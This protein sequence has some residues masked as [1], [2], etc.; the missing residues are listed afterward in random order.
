MHY[1]CIAEATEEKEK[2]PV[3]FF[4]YKFSFL[5]P[6]PFLSAVCTREITSLIFKRSYAGDNMVRD[7][8]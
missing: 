8:Y 2:I 4:F 1:I 3:N 7:I 6:T 5:L